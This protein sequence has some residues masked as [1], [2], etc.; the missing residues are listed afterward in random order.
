VSLAHDALAQDPHDDD[1]SGPTPVFAA[2]YAGCYADLLRYVRARTPPGIDPED[3]VQETFVDAWLAWESYSPERPFWSWLVTIAGRRCADRW[4]QDWRARRAHDREARQPTG[5]GRAP[6]LEPGE[7]AETLEEARLALTAFQDVGPGYQRVIHLRHI[8]GMSYEQIARSE[9][10]TVESVRGQ[11]RRARAALRSRFHTLAEGSPVALGL[12]ALQRLLRRATLAA[13]R[14]QRW[15]PAGD[16]DASRVGPFLAVLLATS[17]GFASAPATAPARPDGV[18]A[19][20]QRAPAVPAA[21]PP[22]R[23]TTARHG[24]GSHPHPSPGSLSAAPAGAERT[25][26][27]TEITPSPRFQ[28]DGTLFATGSSA[29]GC[30]ETCGALL[31]ST[32]AGRTWQRLAA[33]GFLGGRL[34][35]PPGYP[36]DARIFVSGPAGLQASYDGGDT[37][38]TVSPVGGPAALMLDF[39]VANPVVLLGAAPGWRYDDHTHTVAP[40]GM[41]PT[42]T[43]RTGRLTFGVTRGAAGTQTIV[44]GG[45]DAASVATVSVCRDD[46]CRDPL[47]LPGLTG[48]PDVLTAADQRSPAYAWTSSGMYRVG[49]DDL[50]VAAVALPAAGRLASVQRTADALFAAIAVDG[51]LTRLFRSTD[52]GRTWQGVHVDES[53]AP[54]LDSLLGAGAGTLLFAPPAAAGG[55]IACSVD[56]GMS[57]SRPCGG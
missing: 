43:T 55:G 28:D 57:W 7:V 47:L 12:A 41:V 14:W 54:G 32:D 17:S 29:S 9:G 44:V 51:A 18:A 21:V 35:L 27:V 10:T 25:I 11:L 34:L 26:A 19:I 1:P 39:S 52:E 30:A 8:E 53:L 48:T 5:A 3:V 56:G 40:L 6:G 13:G 24:P 22:A 2:L 36:D 38:V 42:P 23:R 50:E 16:S 45:S 20:E 31:R 46:V 4:R 49:L 15:L 37:F 33:V